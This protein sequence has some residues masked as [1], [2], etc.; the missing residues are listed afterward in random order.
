MPRNIVDLDRTIENLK[1]EGS[2]P[3]MQSKAVASLNYRPRTS[4]LRPLIALSVVAAAVLLLLPHGSS[5]M[6]WAQVVKNS[7]DAPNVHSISRYKN[8]AIALEQWA[9]GEKQAWTIFDPSGKVVNEFRG[10][11]ERVFHYFHFQDSSKKT[12]N[13]N[14]RA[15]GELYT[16]MDGEPSLMIP[17]GGSLDQLMRDRAYK[18]VKQTSFKFEGEEAT[19]FELEIT[20]PYPD[21]YHAIVKNKT[22]LISE[23]RRGKD[24]VYKITYP[25]S[26]PSANFEPKPKRVK[27]IEVYDRNKLTDTIKN[28]V[29]N[30]MQTQNGVTVHLVA[31]DYSGALWVLWSGVPVDGQMRKPFTS[32]G[33]SFGKPFGHRRL[34]SS[35]GGTSEE[36]IFTS[37]G[38]RLYGMGREAK[39]LIGKT[40]DLDIPTKHGMARFKGLPVLRIG[41]STSYAPWHQVKGGKPFG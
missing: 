26:I 18:V 27:N 36:P 14:R 16:R 32:I 1:L 33:I 30:G 29:N 41:I 15:F 21:H 34:T 19:D 28:R 10:D 37:D 11:G 35:A 4:R 38:T 3:A 7:L 40:V 8:G 23:I 13:P 6:A 9:Q 12:K 22:G 39:T 31:L 5:G 20:K 25:K 24:F 2:T 17:I